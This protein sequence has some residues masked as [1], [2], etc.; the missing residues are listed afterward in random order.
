M[1]KGRQDWH[2]VGS[3]QS[4]AALGL[5]GEAW[6]PTDLRAMVLPPAIR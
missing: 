5:Q 2:L 3:H 6:G 1:K 4:M